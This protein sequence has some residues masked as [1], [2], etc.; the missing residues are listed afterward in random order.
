MSLLL[1]SA[2]GVGLRFLDNDDLGASDMHER[3][4]DIS[5]LVLLYSEMPE[6]LCRGL[7]GPAMG[8]G[9]RGKRPPRLLPSGRTYPTL[10]LEK[11]SLMST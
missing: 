8:S 9:G 11:V 6:L 4:A 7:L 5:V 3:Q 1:A 2:G 10:N